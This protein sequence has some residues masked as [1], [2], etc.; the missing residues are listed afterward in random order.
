[1][2]RNV[3]DP[4]LLD[5]LGACAQHEPRR[6]ELVAGARNAP[7]EANDPGRG[8]LFWGLAGSRPMLV[9]G[10]PSP[11]RLAVAPGVC[12]WLGP[13]AWHLPQPRRA[14]AFGTLILDRRRII[15]RRKSWRAGGSSVQR[16][17]ES[18]R[19]P[20]AALRQIALAL[21]ELARADPRSAAAWPLVQALVRQCHRQLVADGEEPAD[22]DEWTMI[23][24]YL[25]EHCCRPD[26]GREQV[27]RLFAIHPNH[28][29]RLFA[30][31]GER[32]ID[33]VNALRLERARPLLA[34]GMRVADVARCVG[35]AGGDHFARLFRRRYG[36]TPGLHA[37][38][39]RG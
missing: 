29:S 6:V 13:R 34:S 32:F 11:R 12:C 33:H 24:D 4:E 9:A 1:M 23:R 27:A 16:A 25:E 28:L 17:L 37:R 10:H 19:P 14:Y 38:A 3:T 5:M 35:F 36:V 2:R 26:L 18:R 31:H 15:L 30:R 7:R 22:P 39:S 21:D 20:N 8:R